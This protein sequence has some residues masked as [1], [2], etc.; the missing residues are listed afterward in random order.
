MIFGKVY[1]PEMEKSEHLTKDQLQAYSIGSLKGEEEHEAGRHLL[2]CDKCLKL[3]PPP[4]AERFWQVLM[5]EREASEPP[6]E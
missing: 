5:K 6:A 3:M 2:D 4:T 1:L